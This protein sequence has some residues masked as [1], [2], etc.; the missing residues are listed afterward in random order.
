MA[1]LDGAAQVQMLVSPGPVVERARILGGPP[2]FAQLAG[3]LRRTL[4][5][6]AFPDSTP[7]KLPVQGLLTCSSLTNECTLVLVGGVGRLVPEVRRR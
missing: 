5:P 2:E 4:L 6:I 1:G 3:V 7:I